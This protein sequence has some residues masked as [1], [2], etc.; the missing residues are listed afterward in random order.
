MVVVGGEDFELNPLNTRS[1]PTCGSLGRWW[2]GPQHCHWRPAWRPHCHRWQLGDLL[3]P[4]GLRHDAWQCF[5][6]A[7]LAVP[8]LPGLCHRLRLQIRLTRTVSAE[9]GQTWA[10]TLEIRE[11][12]LI[13]CPDVPE[14]EMITW[15]D[16]HFGKGHPVH[17]GAPWW[18][19]GHH[20]SLASGPS[21][22]LRG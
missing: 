7:T 15:L 21:S 6:A 17:S 9:C 20:A 8:L 10:C 19:D 18:Y 5:L 13:W 16:E 4:C 3:A 1:L 22:P 11:G 2:A 14:K 12:T